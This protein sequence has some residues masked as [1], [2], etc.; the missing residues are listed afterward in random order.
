MSGPLR[1]HYYALRHGISIANEQGIIISH[2]ENGT[3]GW[4]LSPNG[5][6]ECRRLL[7]PEQL[8]LHGFSKSDT[9]VYT[10]DFDRAAETAKIFCELNQ[11]DDPIRDPRLRERNFGRFENSSIDAYDRVWER[12]AGDDSHSFGNCES[13]AALARRLN[14]LLTDLERQ[15]NDRKI[16]LVSHGDPLQVF[17]TILLGLRCNQH[18]GLPHLGNAELRR[19]QPR[20]A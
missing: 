18:R 5:V 9:L 20:E 10:S 3:A 15:W 13:T 17:Q 19:L 16:V 4:G 1:N 11:L 12:D 2:P 7:A 8:R 6:A 14:E